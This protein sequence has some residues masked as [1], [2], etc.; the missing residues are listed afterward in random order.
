MGF[1]LTVGGIVS[2]DFTRISIVSVAPG[3]FSLELG[4]TNKV[5]KSVKRADTVFDDLDRAL[6]ADTAASVR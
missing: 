4:P 2:L 1:L 5:L 6:G 3:S